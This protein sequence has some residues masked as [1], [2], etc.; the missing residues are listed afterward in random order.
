MALLNK[1]QYETF[2]IMVFAAIITTPIVGW[3]I[4]FGFF[5]KSFLNSIFGVNKKYSMPFKYLAF[6]VGYIIVYAGVLI[7]TIHL[8]I[9]GVGF[10]IIFIYC[11]FWVNSIKHS[12]GDEI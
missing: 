2:W 8:G 10:I 5:M 3:L 4:A 6:F 9:P 7:Y 11:F 1:K 12:L